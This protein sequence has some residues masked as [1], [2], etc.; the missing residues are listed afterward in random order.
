[1]AIGRN[2]SCIGS[3]ARIIHAVKV[4]CR[5]V[6]LRREKLNLIQQAAAALAGLLQSH[7]TKIE[8]GEVEPSIAQM[9]RVHVA[10]EGEFLESFFGTNPSTRLVAEAEQQEGP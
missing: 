7:W 3:S 1:M 8:R 4:Y 5:N 2:P 10:L 9:L 6:R